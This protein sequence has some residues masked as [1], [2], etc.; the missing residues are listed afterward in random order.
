MIPK[1]VKESRQKLEK[2]LDSLVFQYLKA[3]T[4]EYCHIQGYGCKCG[5]VLQPNHLITRGQKRI[6]W[7]LDNVVVGCAGHNTWA[8]YH[9]VEWDRLWREL[10][11]ERAKRL[12]L[13]RRGTMD[14]SI[15][16]LRLLI[17]EY[18]KKLRT[19]EYSKFLLGKML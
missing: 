18:E 19:P 11:P 3:T 17:A 5:G 9:Q 16:I 6:R 10:W 8:H 1:P 7:E 2:R 13:K 14:C 4:G 15:P 12:D